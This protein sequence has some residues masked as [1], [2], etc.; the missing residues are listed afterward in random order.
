MGY[1]SDVCLAI[2]PDLVPEFMAVMA[3]SEPARELCWSHTAERQEDF[4]GLKGA[5]FFRWE[6]VK[7][8]PDYEDVAPINE[9]IDWC[10]ENEHH[11]NFRFVRMGE[12]DDD[13]TTE[14]WGFDIYVERQLSY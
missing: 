5:L 7:W 11:D 12:D 4:Q 9:F 1:R 10:N 8:Y 6:S 14:G 3:R 2:H 13:T